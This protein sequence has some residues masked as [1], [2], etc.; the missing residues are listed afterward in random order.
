MPVSLRNV[1]RLRIFEVWVQWRSQLTSSSESIVPKREAA[2][3]RAARKRARAGSRM[4]AR[5]R[6]GLRPVGAGWAGLWPGGACYR[7]IEA[8]GCITS[9]F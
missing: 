1:L 7:L 6:V 4:G 3:G 8:K 5:A 9:S 2:H